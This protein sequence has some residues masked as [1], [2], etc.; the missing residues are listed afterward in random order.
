MLGYGAAALLL[1][2]AG[3]VFLA[4][5]LT[6]LLWESN[7]LLVLGGFTA[8]FLICG[9]IALL[10]AWRFAH[11]KTRLFSSSLA[12]LAEDR[13]ALEGRQGGERP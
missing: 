2:G 11:A 4:I 9:G 10:M 7:R 1:L 3:V 13:A 8:A 12:E 5:F 6:V